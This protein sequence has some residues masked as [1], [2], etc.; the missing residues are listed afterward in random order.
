[1]SHTPLARLLTL[2]FRLLIDGLHE[3]LPERGFPGVRPAFGFVLL[4]LAGGPV[5]MKD[6]VATLG[7][8]KQA[9]SQLV[10]DMVA[11]GYAVRD[12]HPAD[13]RSRT[14]ALSDRGRELL[15]AVEEIYAE[16]EAGWAA[17]IGADRV[18]AIRTDLEGVLRAAHGGV[19][20]ALRP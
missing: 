7:I 14:V 5:T 18:A 15:V 10:V 19:L 13:A 12:V 2:S 9:V 20:P 11:A 6:L 4:A 17:Q 1:M 16:L 3:R 8:T